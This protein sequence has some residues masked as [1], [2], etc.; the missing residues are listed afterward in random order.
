[1]PS[2]FIII[3]AVIPD[4]NVCI[5]EATRGRKP[6]GRMTIFDKF[7][8]DDIRESVLRRVANAITGFFFSEINRQLQPILATASMNNFHEASAHFENLGYRIT[9]LSKSV[10]ASRGK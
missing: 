10:N 6:G 7:L 8:P 1:M 2:Y 3:L 4:P 9:V 5:A